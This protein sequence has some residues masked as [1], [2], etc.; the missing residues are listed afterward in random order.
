MINAD[1]RV[2]CLYQ[3]LL[4]RQSNHVYIRVTPNNSSPNEASPILR[5][6]ASKWFRVISW[7]RKMDNPQ[8]QPKKPK[9]AYFTDSYRIRE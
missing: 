4:N 6:E 8:Q 9:I 2:Y 5:I 7:T 3:H 1:R